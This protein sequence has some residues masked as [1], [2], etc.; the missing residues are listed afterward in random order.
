MTS[1]SPEDPN[2]LILPLQVLRSHTAIGSR[3]GC[4]ISYSLLMAW[5]DSWRMAHVLGTLN[6]HGSPERGSWLWIGPALAVVTS[7]GMSH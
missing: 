5:E 2:W 7:W 1:L 6:L 4:A 3:P